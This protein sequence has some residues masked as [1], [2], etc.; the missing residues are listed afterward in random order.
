DASYALFGSSVTGTGSLNGSGDY[1]ASMRMDA[2]D[3][4]S[5]VGDSLR[6][7]MSLDG[8]LD[9][10]VAVLG[11]TDGDYFATGSLD[12]LYLSGRGQ[13]VSLDAPFTFSV[14]PD[15]VRATDFSLTG[16]V[17]S[18]AGSL[19]YGRSGTIESELTLQGLNLSKAAALLPEPL[20]EPP[21]G[22]LGGRLVISGT[23][24]SPVLTMDVGVSGLG[25]R[26]V[27]LDT[28]SVYV[29][30]DTAA[31]VFDVSAESASSG[32]VWAGGSIPVTR[33]SATV[34]AFDRT[35]EFG[36]TI[37]CRDLVLDA[38]DAVLPGV[39][40]TKRLSLDGSA[41]LTGRADSLVSING[42]GQLD[43]LVVSMD[44]V[45]F[46]LADTMLFQVDDGEVTFDEIGFNLVRKRVLGDSR[47]GSM[48]LEGK[49]DPLGDVDIDAVIADLD[50]GHLARAFAGGS[51]MEFRGDLSADVS[52]RG[53]T[54]DPDVAFAWT[55]RSPRLFGFGFDANHGNG[56][57]RGGRLVVETAELSAG[58]RSI[59][60]TGSVLTGSGRADGDGR[61]SKPAPV[62]YDLTV[63]ARDFRLKRIRVL[64]PGL[65]QLSGRLD[66]DM[67]LSGKGDSVDLRGTLAVSDGSM[68]GFGLARPIRNLTASVE[69]Q[70]TAIA[71]KEARA[72]VGSGSVELSGLVNFPGG[73][74]PPTFYARARLRSAEV[75]I[76]DTFEGKFE[77]SLDWGGTPDGSSLQGKLTVADGVVT[78]SI[79]LGDVVA[80]GPRVIVVGS[81]KDRRSDVH[82]NVDLNIEDE[83]KV[84]SNLAQLSLAGGGLVRGTLLEPRVSGGVEGEGGT[85]S[86]L[87]NDFTVETLNVSFL[88]PNRRDPYVALTGT[89]EVE[90]RSGQTYEVT[91]VLDGYLFDAVPVLTSSPALSEPDIFSL[92][93]FGTTFGGLVSGGPDTNTSGD[94]FR[95]MAR[96][97]FISNAFGL[98]ENAL[99]RLLDLDQVII[100]EEAM[101]SGDVAST[102]VTIG[103]E[104]AGRVR[105]NYTTSVGRFSGQRVEVSFELT[106]RLSLE[107][108]TDPEGNHA[109]GLKLQIPFK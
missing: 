97:A 103:K 1:E 108:R 101:M 98:A 78:R 88:D 48:S 31:V 33:D 50:V 73:G 65:D 45:D 25:M 79:G 26:G 57:Y 4:A 12:E 84:D 64:P 41:L 96:S 21:E 67:R 99:E 47:G 36:A 76:E 14:S 18:I 40:G 77:G 5:L 39:R 38:S 29:E 30:G 17:G 43:R 3:L 90:D 6:A 104:F 83:L 58:D 93:T 72:D 107:S 27:S 11:N 23:K 24:E 51:G 74:A 8:R 92:L 54:R 19:T 80:R 55:M 105:V 10:E 100:D 13:S 68:E 70:G 32:S 62:E 109:I 69:A 91:V 28:L 61:G 22:V 94:M 60:V 46:V 75:K 63:T 35:R 106:R 7:A 34:F 89:A 16:D 95:N 56:T 9:G 71:L 44:L 49:F 59:S 20:D 102:G 37:L 15:S 87:D 85:F 53:E 66:A 2:F 86:Y 81:A 52:V 82:L 42:S